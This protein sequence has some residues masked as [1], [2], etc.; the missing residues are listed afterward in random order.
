MATSKRHVRAAI[1]ELVA[2]H[3]HIQKLGTSVARLC[4]EME[5][6]RAGNV[7]RIMEID[8]NGLLIKWNESME[9]VTRL[10]PQA[11]AELGI[12]E[13]IPPTRDRNSEE[14]T[15]RRNAPAAPAAQEPV[16]E[17]EPVQPTNDELEKL[18]ELTQAKENENE[19]ESVEAETSEADTSS[20][21]DDWAR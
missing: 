7:K 9:R 20:N 18:K 4:V 21:A 13:W 3:G 19:P 2:M 10:M 6:E 14:E 8:M 11:T 12:S 17:M 1:D 15:T 5:H 16:V